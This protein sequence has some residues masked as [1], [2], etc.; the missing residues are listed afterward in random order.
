MSA[1]ESVPVASTVHSVA[2]ESA[3]GGKF[4][5]RVLRENGR[6]DWE[7]SWTAHILPAEVSGDRCTVRFRRTVRGK[8]GDVDREVTVLL[9]GAPVYGFDG[10][11]WIGPYRVPD[12]VALLLAGWKLRAGK[13]NSSEASRAAG[14]YLRSF[15]AEREF[16]GTGTVS[17][18]LDVSVFLAGRR[19]ISGTV[20]TLGEVRS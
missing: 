14:I 20:E 15:S 17:V 19:I 11:A 4:L 5:R 1:A 8:V 6:G 10:S 18:S 13:A 12:V 16:P 9:A 2:F 7:S 3:E